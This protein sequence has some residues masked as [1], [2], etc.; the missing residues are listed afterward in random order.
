MIPPGASG[1]EWK[2]CSRCT[3]VLSRLGLAS[4]A[5]SQPDKKSD[6]P[7]D[8]LRAERKPGNSHVTTRGAQITAKDFR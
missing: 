8:R 4:L 3:A 1:L 6:V 7:R 5:M 2:R